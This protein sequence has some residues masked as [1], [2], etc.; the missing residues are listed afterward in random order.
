MV[1]P[2]S[3]GQSENLLL[4]ER[5]GGGR[6]RFRETYVLK[7]VFVPLIGEDGYPG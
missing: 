6:P 7:C 3:A 2:V 1:I 4:V 5:E